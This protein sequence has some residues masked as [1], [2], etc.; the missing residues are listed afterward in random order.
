LLVRGLDFQDAKKVFA[1]PTLCP[2]SARITAKTD[3]KRT[4]CS[5]VGWSW[6][7]GL[8]AAEIAT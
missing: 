1:G 4:V 2:T 3:I 6:W 7:C 8:Y 5:T